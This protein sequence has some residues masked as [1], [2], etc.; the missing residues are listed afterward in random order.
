VSYI[1]KDTYTHAYK[2]MKHTSKY[3][4]F[5]AAASHLF[6]NLQRQRLKDPALGKDLQLHAVYAIQVLGQNTAV[7]VHMLARKSSIQHWQYLQSTVE[8]CAIMGP[9]GTGKS[10]LVYGWCLFSHFQLSHNVVYLWTTT[11]S[12][13]IAVLLYENGKSS[14]FFGGVSSNCS[15]KAIIDEISRLYQ[16][17]SLIVIDGL[18]NSEPVREW[19][20]AAVEMYTSHVDVKFVF[21]SSVQLTI[22]WD[23]LGTLKV[24]EM[25][26]QF[27][28]W[29]IE[30]YEY[31]CRNKALWKQVSKYFNI[32]KGSNI[33]ANQNVMKEAIKDKY[34]YAGG[35]ARWM[36]SLPVAEICNTI[37]KAARSVSNWGELLKLSGGDAAQGSVNSLVQ[38]RI[39]PNSPDIVETSLI[40]AYA[41]QSIGQKADHSVVVAMWDWAVGHGNKAVM[42]WAYEARCINEWT[43]A[44][45]STKF[46]LTY[47]GVVGEAPNKQLKS[48]SVSPHTQERNSRKRK[49]GNSDSTLEVALGDEPLNRRCL[50]TDKGTVPD[51]LDMSNFGLVDLVLLPSRWNQGGFDVVFVKN[52]D[53]YFVQC[54]I[55]Q[56]HSRK[57]RFIQALV[58]SL[59]SKGFVVEN[60]NLIGCVPSGSFHDF[61]FDAY[62]GST[63]QGT[64][65]VCWKTKY[66][67]GTV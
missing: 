4:P 36:F 44:K 55:A 62:E 22:K 56:N 64:K 51:D 16:N 19:L 63:G 48:Y 26:P 49:R 61:K 23:Q 6:Q 42:G 30:E 12:T 60:V 2:H 50:L 58:T 37:D 32:P 57:G 53:I 9:P 45:S 18:R 66:D 47:L 15:P 17:I 10:T 39:P 34:Y 24:K 33:S 67:F 54:T 38:I 11:D 46:C 14:Y 8:H 40:S 25:K 35:C 43:R 65:I 31:A 20:G 21:V 41:F 7:I 52:K 5:T 29:A 1:Q 27:Q 13:K 28:S 3:T 59:S